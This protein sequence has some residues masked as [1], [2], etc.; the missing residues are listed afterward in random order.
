MKALVINHYSANKGDR[1]ILY[2]VVR[3]LARNKAQSITV[4]TNDRSFWAT[5]M[6]AEGQNVN[7]VPWGQCEEHPIG[8][9]CI[10]MLAIRAANKFRRQ[11]AFPILKSFLK[12]KIFGVPPFFATRGFAKALIEADI[13]IGTGG[14]HIQTRFTPE[15][16]SS[17]TYDM[18]L[19][20]L[21]NKPL[22]L[23]SQSIGPLDFLNNKN[24]E[25]VRNIVDSSQEI[26]LRDK[27]SISELCKI[28][29]QLNHIRETYD[30]VIGLN[31][32]IPVYQFINERDAVIGISVYSAESRTPDVFHQYVSS[33]AGFIDSAAESGYRIRFFPMEMK[34][35]AADDRPCIHAVLN[36]VRRRDA[37]EVIEDDLDTVAHLR[38]VAKCRVFVGHKTHSQ[39]FAFT[40]G[41]P[42][43]AL[44][45]H[46]K[47]VD[48]M[49]QYDLQDNCVLDSELTAKRLF[50]VFQSICQSLEETAFHQYEVSRKYGELVRQSFANMLRHLQDGKKTFNSYQNEL[51]SNE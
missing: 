25:F 43:I 42:L 9:K 32:E 37:C 16:L 23:W 11:Y 38:E 13:V 30:S 41:T 44:A 4:S 24:K 21:A 8:T 40:V 6:N 7:F 49:T 46:E 39:I 36:C 28:G 51:P 29:A 35:A 10:N 14:H 15:S 48:F 19:T 26:Y 22:I 47:T 20:L 45:Y 34:R 12:N 18:A 1:A 2:F 27:N 31:D 5:G 33:L 50:N 17:L 3:E